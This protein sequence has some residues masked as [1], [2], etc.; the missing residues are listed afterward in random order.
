MYFLFILLLS[1][2]IFY[3]I[4]VI[5]I[6]LGLFRIPTQTQDVQETVSVIVAAR[7]EGNNILQLLNALKSQDY[8]LDKLS[9]VIVDDMSTDGMLK[10]ISVFKNAFPHLKLEV[11]LSENR[12]KVVSPKKNALALGITKS[13]GDILIFTDADCLPPKSWI[14]GIVKLFT[15]SVGMVIGYSPYEVPH[16]NSLMSKLIGMDAL[17]LAALA[18]GTSGW[19]RPATCNGRNLAYRRDVHEQV[20]GYSGI[21]QFVSGDDDLFLK[22][23][24]QKKQWQVRYAYSP[25]LVVSTN[26][27]SGWKQFFNQ[28]LRHASK[29]FFYSSKQVVVL[30]LL[31]LYYLLLFIGGPIG[32]LYG[33]W[34]LVLSIL[35]L[36]SVGEFSLLFLFAKHMNRLNLMTV[37]PIAVLLYI[38]YVVIFGLLGQFASFEW[39]G[40]KSDAINRK[41]VK[42]VA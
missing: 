36:K 32:L 3:T 14:S 5:F 25:Q 29:G 39:K 6:T 10:I 22:K 31:Y 15:S 7:N 1:L 34:P 28:R 42:R 16:T 37:F 9:I 38:P 12:E 21:N 26:I 41:N 19:G 20:G 30:T 8:P 24:Q 13:T 33:F 23:V 11:Y 2:T 4:V 17:A 35:L 27:L 18:A 40:E